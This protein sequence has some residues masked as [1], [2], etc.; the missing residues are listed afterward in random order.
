MTDLRPT[1]KAEFDHEWVDVIAEGEPIDAGAEIEVVD[2]R[3]NRVVVREMP[4]SA[5]K[6]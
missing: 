6:A 3:A 2:A 5:N 1:G 4:T